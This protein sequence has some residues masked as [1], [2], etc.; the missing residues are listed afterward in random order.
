[1]PISYV[2]E[3]VEIQTFDTD[4]NGE[5]IIVRRI[6][7]ES[8]KR[9]QLVQVDFFEDAIPFTT[10]GQEQIQFVVSAYPSVPTDMR[11]ASQVVI[12]DRLVSAGDDSVLFKA[13]GE[14]SDPTVVKRTSYAQ[15]PSTQIAAANFAE[16]YS[17]HIYITIKWDGTPNTAYGNIGLSFLFVFKETNVSAITGTL[18]KMA[19]Q[20]DAMC[21]LIMSTGSMTSQATLR[22]N[23][24]PAWRYGGIR[25]EHTI[26]P[27]ATNSFFLEIDTRDPESMSTTAQ[28]RQNVADARRMAAYDGA[29]GERRPDWLREELNAGITTG[30][31]RSD[32]VPLKYADNGNTRMF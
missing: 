4:A 24:F 23:T 7:L 31:I 11:Y 30:P 18:G 6:N 13:V 29:F 3:T 15:F 17:D 14:P 12:P 10:T 28:I 1:M 32:Q 19:E 2:K 16:F 21:A 26:T 20:H 25:P 22:G 9:R 8:G 27:T 5:A